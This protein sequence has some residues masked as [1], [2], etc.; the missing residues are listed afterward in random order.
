M[1][2]EMIFYRLFV[3]LILGVTLFK[4]RVNLTRCGDTCIDI[5]LSSLSAH[6]LGSGIIASF[7]L[8]EI[9]VGIGL[10]V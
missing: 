10:D 2:E 7:E 3:H 5:C 6:L 8:C 9:L 1:A 4:E